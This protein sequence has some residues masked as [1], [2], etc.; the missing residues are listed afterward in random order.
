LLTNPGIIAAVTFCLLATFVAVPARAEMNQVEALA[1]AAAVNK[2]GSDE[3]LQNSTTSA[4][5][6]MLELNNQNRPGAVKNG[7]KAFGEYRT[8][9]DLDVVRMKNRIRQIDLFTNNISINTPVPAWA[10]NRE[11]YATTFA[12][13]DPK[14]LRQGDAAKVAE[15]FERKS[16]MRRETFLKKLAQVSESTISADDPNLADKVMGKFATFVEDIPN[17]QFRENVKK[18]IEATSPSS[19]AKLIRDGANHIWDVL[20][21]Y[22]MGGSPKVAAILPPGVSEAGR[23]PAS[24]V[25]VAS[26]AFPGDVPRTAGRTE[27][28]VNA[29]KGSFHSEMAPRDAD[30]KSLNLAT[31]P[32]GSAMQAAL[33]EQGEL[34]IFKQVSKRYRAVTPLLGLVKD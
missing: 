22:G 25:T 33:D 2:Q 34:T 29:S 32:L 23:A 14:F 28:P 30:L 20:A 15:E 3:S 12:R 26:G 9:E 24:A 11:V 6:A 8:S 18:Q 5:R 13:L 31:E 21:S 27:D 10:A 7:Y 4:M 1:A 16:G 19:Q 17:A